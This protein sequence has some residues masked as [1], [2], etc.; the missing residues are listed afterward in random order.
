[1]RT[2]ITQVACASFIG[3]AIAAPAS[4]G[5]EILE[6]S[7]PLTNP[8]STAWSAVLFE[9]EPDETAMDS[10]SGLCRP[11]RSDRLPLGRGHRAVRA[12]TGSR[13][14]SISTMRSFDNGDKEVVFEFDPGDPKWSP[15]DGFV[16]FNLTIETPDADGIPFEIRDPADLHSLARFVGVG[17]S[18]G[19]VPPETSQPVISPDD[20]HRHAI[21]AQNTRI[22]AT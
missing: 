4:A 15:S 13:R 8:T 7:F 19:A 11:L 12:S 22:L 16:N 17:W 1:M 14:R 21:V 9:I 10:R 2:S 6:Y 20:A 18:R 5:T 3:A